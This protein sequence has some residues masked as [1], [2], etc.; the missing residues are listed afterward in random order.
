MAFQGKWKHY[1]DEGFDA[2]LDAIGTPEEAK[3][4][5]L[6]SHPVIDFSRDGDYYVVRFTESGGTD[7]ESRFKEGEE[8]DHPASVADASNTRRV[9]ATQLSDSKFQ[10]KTVSGSPDCVETRDVIDGELVTTL[11]HGSVTCKRYFKKV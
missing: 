1:K 10:I 11:E 5:A 6:A 4:V 3:K 9:V 8:F 2:F 7:R